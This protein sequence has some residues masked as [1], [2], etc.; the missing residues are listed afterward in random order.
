[1]SKNYFYTENSGV[2]KGP[3]D[4]DE[5]MKEP[6]DGS[7][8]IWFEGLPE[9][10]ELKDIPPLFDIYNSVKK[11]K[12]GKLSN[13]NQLEPK[14]TVKKDK[15]PGIII[16]AIS[17]MSILII[18]MLYIAYRPSFFSGTFSNKDLRRI[19]SNY[20]ATLNAFE[21]NDFDNA[22]KYIDP[23]GVDIGMTPEQMGTALGMGVGLAYKWG[24]IKSYEY[25]ELTIQDYTERIKIQGEDYRFVLFSTTGEMQIDP[26]Y[27][28][29]WQIAMLGNSNNCSKIEMSKDA[30]EITIIG[31]ECTL[32]RYDNST[33]EW[34]YSCNFENQQF[35]HTL[36]TEAINLYF[37]NCPCKGK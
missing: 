18:F 26:Q 22:F 16:F 6:I 23:K 1:M 8:F 29:F 36:P 27:A 13:Y 19:K 4:L 7:T 9:W 12:S 25:G 10:T 24:G 2:R 11:N 32:W 33:N 21:N 5:I 20:Q 34:L 37:A 3:F 15:F 17:M 30:T 28:F 14:P 35:N 31:K